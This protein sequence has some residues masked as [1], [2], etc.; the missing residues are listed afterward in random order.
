MVDRDTRRLLC[1]RFV[2]LRKQQRTT[3]RV[4]PELTAEEASSLRRLQQLAG[5]T[6]TTLVPL[7]DRALLRPVDGDRPR[8]HLIELAAVRIP[9]LCQ[10]FPAWVQRDPTGWPQRSLEQLATAFWA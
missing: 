10:H 8:G 9:D 4:T 1:R 6:G 7:G 3:H 2:E 5:R